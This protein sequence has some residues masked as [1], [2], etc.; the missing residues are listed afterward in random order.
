M[1]IP[2]LKPD[3]INPPSEVVLWDTDSTNHYV[4]IGHA[5]KMGFPTRREN[6]RV[7]TIGGDIK[8]IDG[9]LFQCQIV[10][11]GGKCRRVCSSWS[12]RSDQNL[13]LSLNGEATQ[14]D[15]SKL[16][17]NSQASQDT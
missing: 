11:G 8:V 3:G 1:N 9:I 7:C 2:T 4:R 16:P 10:N 12:G 14:E 6:M 13:K 17:N 5:E 15:V